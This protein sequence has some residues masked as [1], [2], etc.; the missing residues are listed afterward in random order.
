M[1]KLV[2]FVHKTSALSTDLPGVS[3]GM[4]RTGVSLQQQE[5]PFSSSHPLS[6]VWDDHT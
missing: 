5:E 6:S 1:L 2:C 3:H 4:T